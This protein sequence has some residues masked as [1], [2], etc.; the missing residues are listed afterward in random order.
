[1][2]TIHVRP[3]TALQ[4]TR[5]SASPPRSPLS[6]GTLGRIRLMIS[7]GVWSAFV[8]AWAAASQPIRAQQ[9]A[10][11]SDV[12]RLRGSEVTLF[13]FRGYW[14]GQHPE[15][16]SFHGW[17]V[18]CQA[19]LGPQDRD[20][21]LNL[22]QRIAVRQEKF[23]KEQKLTRDHGV[24][25]GFQGCIGEV[26]G[27]RFEREGF[28]VDVYARLACGSDL[29]PAFRYPFRLRYVFTGP[30][31]QTFSGLFESVLPCVGI[32]GTVK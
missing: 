31:L 7:K 23:V 3:N 30:E 15:A 2:V 1:M 21:F 6:F 25:G 29:R 32:A 14:N 28:V 16:E 4:R 13:R 5:S 26:Y 18:L 10:L 17:E 9:L 8:V 27:V 11:R 24:E 20:E 22:L 19:R 12:E